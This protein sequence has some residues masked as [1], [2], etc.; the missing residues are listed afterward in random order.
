MQDLAGT[1]NRGT[2]DILDLMD[3]VEYRRV[4]SQEDLEDVGWLRYRA[5][6]AYGIMNR[7]GPII[8]ELDRHSHARVFAVYYRGAMISTIRLHHLVSDHRVATS[9]ELFPDVLGPLL[10]QGMTFIDSV[11]H[12][13]DPDVLSE[14]PVPFLTLRLVAMACHHLKANYTLAPVKRSHAP[15]YRRGFGATQFADERQHPDFAVPFVLLASSYEKLYESIMFSRYP[16]FQSLPYERQ[17]LFAPLA[18]LSEI[19]LTI[20]PT[21]RL[22][23]QGRERDIAAA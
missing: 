18:E 3:E 13:S 11:R 22:A 9:Y 8:D 17:L 7:D 15:L 21:A 4:V 19:P 12:A 5:Y 6:K 23:L 14:L 10:D 2:P 16:F 1:L 20:R